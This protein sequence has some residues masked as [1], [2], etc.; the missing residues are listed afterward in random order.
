MRTSFIAVASAF[1]GMSLLAAQTADDGARAQVETPTRPARPTRGAPAAQPAPGQPPVERPAYGIQNYSPLAAAGGYKRERQTFW[2]FWWYQFNPRNVNYGA[3]IEQRRQMFLEQAG[4]NRYFWF[5]FWAFATIC[6]LL[7]W[8]A[9]ERMDR[10]DTEWEAAECLADLANY[11]DYCKRHALEA[12]QKHNEHIEVCNRVIESTETGRPITPGSGNEEQWKAEVERLRTEVAETAAANRKLTAELEKKTTT[13][14]DLS[15]RI[16][17]LERNHAERANGA[18]A[19]MDLVKRL[20]RLTDEVQ[21]LREENSR[22][23]RANQNAG[24]SERVR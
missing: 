4:A 9:K 1:L 17:E 19:N 10:K 8:A 24:S 18:G 23:K 3:W 15:H 11:A 14:T 13:V 16:D 22:L 5:S 2:E 6:F 21:A 20:N 7:L 12:I